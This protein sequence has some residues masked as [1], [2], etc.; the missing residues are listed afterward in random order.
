MAGASVLAACLLMDANT[1]FKKNRNFC[2]VRILLRG[3]P[4]ECNGATGGRMVPVSTCSAGCMHDNDNDMAR[5]SKQ[6]GSDSVCVAPSIV[7]SPCLDV[8]LQSYIYILLEICILIEV[9]G[10]KGVRF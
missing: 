9:Q 5:H 2:W 3:M 6:R 7:S 10:H 1:A 8:M 4:K